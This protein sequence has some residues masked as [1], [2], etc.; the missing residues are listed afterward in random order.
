M[1]SDHLLVRHY[2]LHSNWYASLTVLYVLFQYANHFEGGRVAG[3]DTEIR[4]P[5]GGDD[6]NKPDIQIREVIGYLLK[7]T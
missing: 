4:S 2:N 7:Y 6:E 5:F 3:D 1:S